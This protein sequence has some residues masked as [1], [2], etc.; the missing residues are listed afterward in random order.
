[1]DSGIDLYWIPLGEGVGGGL[2]RWSGRI[3]EALTA[4]VHRRARCALYHS[5]LA[6]HLDGTTTIV[7]MAPVWTK[8]GDRGVVSE[9]PVGARFLGRSRLFRYEV[10]RWEGGAI[11][12]I[13]AAVGGALRVS[14]SSDDAQNAL[15]ATATFPTY[16]WGRDD[17]GAGDM[18]NSNSLTAWS[19]VRAGL[20]FDEFGPPAGGR[21]PGWRAG[22]VAA[23]VEP[24]T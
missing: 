4:V 20:A 3:Y 23:S 12:D 11:A 8:R 17:L 19:L 18:W 1:M 21:A 13:A 14:N 7:E 24:A 6:I 2:V 15:D 10:R 16:T 22:I 5:A 9:G